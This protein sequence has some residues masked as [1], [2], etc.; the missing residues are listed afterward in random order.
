ML[1]VITLAA[2]LLIAWIFINTAVHKLADPSYIAGVIKRQVPWLAE[3]TSRITGV[4]LGVVEGLVAVAILVPVTRLAGASV[5]LGLLTLYALMMVTQ[6]LRGRTDLD[7]GC[8]G[9]ARRQNISRK[10][11][12]RNIALM[13]IA[14]LVVL[15]SVAV[16]PSLQMGQDLWFVAI[17]FTVLSI[18]V[19]MC[20][21]QLMN[22]RQKL[23]SLK[24]GQ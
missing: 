12:V 23:S 4:V 20:S 21:E 16:E 1:D 14:A 3:S 2:T 10:L 17:P 6:L 18:L 7:C 13:L 15:Q 8:S 5:A 24:G 9:P 11:V 22:N 19:Y